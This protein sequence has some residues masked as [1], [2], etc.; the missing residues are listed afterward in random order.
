MPT[1]QTHRSHQRG[2]VLVI[3]LIL[4]L[5]ITV[6]ALATMS[7]TNMQERMAGNARTQALAFEVASLG[8]SDALNFYIEQRKS[9]TDDKLLCG[10]SS[11]AWLTPPPPVVE[12]V[13][14]V[15]NHPARLTRSMH[16]I[17]P[18]TEVEETA[19]IRPQLF[20]VSRGEILARDNDSIALARRS[21]AV[22]IS[23][24]PPARA[25]CSSICFPGC[26]TEDSF[27]FPNSNRFSVDGEG[28]PAITTTGEDCQAKVETSIGENRI[29]NYD[30]GVANFEDE[31]L[32]WPWTDPKSVNEFRQ[33]LLTK[34]GAV[35]VSTDTDGSVHDTPIEPPTGEI[36]G[37]NFDYRF[38]PEGR[39][40]MGG[41]H[42]FG[43][44]S[45][46][47]I[48][49]IA[50]DAKMGGDV[51]GAGILVVEGSLSWNGTPNFNGLILVLGDSLEID[52]GGQGGNFAGSLVTVNIWEDYTD[53]GEKILAEDFG[54]IDVVFKGGG[55]ANYTF[56][57][58]DLQG[59]SGEL[60]LGAEDS[61]QTTNWWPECD[62][63]A[64]G[65]EDQFKIVS[66]RETLGWEVDRD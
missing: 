54:P 14:D 30:G 62:Q 2:V 1:P 43:T 36:G 49:Y 22:R 66:W 19:A 3:G 25:D 26:S 50:G 42:E 33:Q 10:R 15:D 39:D 57:C 27:Q 29:G 60:G 52:G 47:A 11:G 55:A 63:E 37:T 21:L 53:F 5:M 40:F 58:K 13:F 65:G 8:A 34:M 20:I 28:A 38:E 31:S 61:D 23:L 6:L 24:G 41:T 12:P 44:E 48:T 9:D 17:E 56:G 35:A 4:L 16:C 59:Y 51:S 7:S 64:G 46:P 45:E 32:P 18:A